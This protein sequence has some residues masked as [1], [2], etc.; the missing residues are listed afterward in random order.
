MKLELKK[1]KFYDELSEETLCYTAELHVDGKKVA[2]VKNDGRGGCS[3][4]YFTEGWR[5]E[6]AQQLIQYIKDNPI[7]IKYNWG[8]HEVKTVED[9]ADH[10]F[11]EW[12]RKKETR[13]KK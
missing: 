5:S 4:V 7:K 3:S 6:S 9:L 8:V 13:R 11:D 10:L 12:L 2:T 1:V